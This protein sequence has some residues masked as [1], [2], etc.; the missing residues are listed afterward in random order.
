MLSKNAKED[1]CLRKHLEECRP[2]LN[3]AHD[4]DPRDSIFPPRNERIELGRYGGVIPG[5][6]VEAGYSVEDVCRIEPF[7]TPIEGSTDPLPHAT[8]NVVSHR[9]ESPPPGYL[10]KEVYVHGAI[11][12]GGLDL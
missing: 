10:D 7:D 6:Y 9:T 4:R 5:G 12:D 8:E 11:I 3:Q 2:R 1:G